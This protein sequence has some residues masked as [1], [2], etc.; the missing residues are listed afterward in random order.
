MG[1]F[2]AYAAPGGHMLLDRELYLPRE[3]ADHAERRQEAGA[4]EAVAF[5]TKPELARRMVERTRVAGVPAAW[6]TGDSISGGDRR[7]RVWLEQQEQ[8]FVLAVTSAELLWAVLDGHRGSHALTS[9]PNTSPLRHG[10][11]S[12]LARVPRGRAG[13]TEPRCA[14]RGCN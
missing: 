8:H 12:R 3:W 1:V 5:A 7:L 11:A 10:S 6:V 4:P 14:W 9:S 13:T 2:L